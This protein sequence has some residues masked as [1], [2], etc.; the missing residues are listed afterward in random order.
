MCAVQVSKITS[1]VELQ[2]SKITIAKVKLI[3]TKIRINVAVHQ[4]NCSMY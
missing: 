3:Y 4:V 1:L 2:T